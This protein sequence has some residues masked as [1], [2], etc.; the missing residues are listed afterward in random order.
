MT[1]TEMAVLAADRLQGSSKSIADLGSEFE[2]L[3]LNSEFCAKLDELVF[4]CTS[5]DNW[6]EQSEMSDVEDW[7]CEEC[8]A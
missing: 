8:P 3:E 1:P 6:F 4:C 2:D 7:V 5:C